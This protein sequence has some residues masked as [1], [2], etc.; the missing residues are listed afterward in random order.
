MKLKLHS[1]KQTPGCSFRDKMVKIVV[2]NRT[3][4]GITGGRTGADSK[5]NEQTNH[6]M[7]GFTNSTL[8]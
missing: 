3:G 1:D 5:C 8:C 6:T 4:A 7:A 2:Y